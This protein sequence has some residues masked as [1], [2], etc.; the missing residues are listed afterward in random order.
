MR[1]KSWIVAAALLAAPLVATASVS[2]EVV[3]GPMDPVAQ[4]GV[5]HGRFRMFVQ[6]RGS[7][8]HRE[9]LDVEARK[10]NVA[11]TTRATRPTFEVFLVNSD[12]SSSADMG[13]MRVNGRGQGFLH[14]DTNHTSLPSGVTTLADFGGGTIEVR[15]SGGNAVCRGSVPNF[16][17]GEQGS[18]VFGRAQEN[19]VSTSTSSNAHGHIFVRRQAL[20]RTVQETLEL[21]CEKLGSSVTYTAVAIASDSTETQLRTFTTRPRGMGGFRIVTR[22]GGSMPGGSVLNLAGQTVEVRDGSGAAVLTGTF[23]TIPSN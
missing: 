2:R 17:G 18:R 14:F 1:M 7:G 5:E 23:P 9:H 21:D 13:P 12:A 19:L 15:D 16:G 10:L 22:A 3:R 6:D 4:G 20:P 8:R 11:G